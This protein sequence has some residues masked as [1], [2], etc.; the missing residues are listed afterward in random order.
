MAQYEPYYEYIG[1]GA[2][3]RALQAAGAR[4]DHAALMAACSDAM[5]ES[6]VL[7]GTPDEVRRRLDAM[8]DIADSFTLSIPFYGLAPDKAATTHAHRG[9][10]LWLTC[11]SPFAGDSAGR[12]KSA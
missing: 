6:I 5:V 2:E 12:Y 4:Q 7:A 10:V 1:F 9:G 3:A 8:A 11:G